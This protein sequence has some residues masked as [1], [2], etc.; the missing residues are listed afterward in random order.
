MAGWRG[1][2]IA[3]NIRQDIA[4]CIFLRVGGGELA[5]ELGVW[6]HLDSWIELVSGGSVFPVK[7]L[8]RTATRADPNVLAV[9]SSGAVSEPPGEIAAVGGVISSAVRSMTVDGRELRLSPSVWE[10]HGVRPFCTGVYVPLG[11]RGVDV[12]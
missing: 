10:P 9:S 2:V 11:G 5:V 8:E 6:I 4:V 7:V 3:G 1:T 12:G